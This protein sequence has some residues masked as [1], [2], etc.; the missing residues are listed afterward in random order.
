VSAA[1][2]LSLQGLGC[3]GPYGLEDQT[4]AVAARNN[5]NRNNGDNE[6]GFRLCAQ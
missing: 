6:N 5:W 3:C 2:P 1:T 4:V